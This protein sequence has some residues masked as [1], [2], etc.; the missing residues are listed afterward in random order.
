MHNNI[1][2]DT[3]NSQIYIQSKENLSTQKVPQ[4]NTSDGVINLSKAASEDELVE[5]ADTTDN[6]TKTHREIE[7]LLEEYNT[8]MNEYFRCQLELIKLQREYE[9]VQREIAKC[10]D[11]SKAAS[12]QA[13]ASGLNQSIVTANE[14]M[15]MC[16]EAMENINKALLNATVEASAPKENI[17]TDS[18]YV[19]QNTETGMQNTQYSGKSIPQDVA[20]KLDKKLG[21]GFSQK[22]EQ[23][24]AKLNCNPGDL[25]AMMYSESGLNPKAQN[26]AGG[27][28][29]LI[30]FIPSTLSANG[31]SSGQVANMSAVQQLD[32]VADILMKS[33]TMSGFAQNE[34]LDAGSLYAICF[35]PAAA[36]SDVLC[37]SS[38]KLN[39]AYSANSA[40]DLDK[41][42]SISKN[43][44]ARRL[45][46]KYTEMINNI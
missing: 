30:Q 6:K 12:L 29:G 38:G 10:D 24:A 33:K 7:T 16:N 3:N 8:E 1:N 9:E 27:A 2:I 39:W 18:V 40:L 15:Q 35:L 45:N 32:V 36:K 25:L 42:G 37:S 46:G 21:N 4:S 31:Y 28:V 19:N 17:T 34:K 41:D 23:V 22:C 13:R 11:K 14:N 5:F 44:L 43:D 20:A 26:A